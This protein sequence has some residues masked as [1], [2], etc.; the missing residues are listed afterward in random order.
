MDWSVR[1]AIWV[2]AVGVIA[3][4]LYL[5]RDALSQ[6]ALALILWLAID[7]LAE[8]LDKRIP[9]TPKW[10]ALPIALVLVLGT[11]ALIGWVVVANL[12]AMADNIPAYQARLDQLIAQ[13]YVGLHGPGTPP[14]LANLFARV[15]PARMAG[16]FAS[17][18]RDV[19]S[20]AGFILIYLAFLI[21]ASAVM[22]KKFNFIFGRGEARTAARDVI[23]RIRVSMERY[24]WVQTVVSLIITALTYVT[25]LAL[26]LENALFWAFLIFFLNYIPTIGSVV[27]VVLTTLVALVQFPSPTQALGVLAGVSIWQFLIGN[28]VQPRMTSDS[29]NLSAVVMLLA[30]SIWGAIWG[31]AGAFLAAPLTVMLMIVLAQFQGTRWIAI[32]LSADG[33]PTPELSHLSKSE[34]GSV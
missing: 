2:I 22:P 14:T 8:Q 27:A 5:L 7:G 19:A 30:L 21:P 1:A 17:G 32:L 12:G 11:V 26:G 20:T 28:F 23:H 9:Y 4:I 34:S 31:L 33:R 6:F 3:A 16:D 18:L 10:L 29:L 13:T 25:L 15:D 24:L